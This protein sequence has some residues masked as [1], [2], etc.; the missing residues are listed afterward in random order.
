MSIVHLSNSEVYSRYRKEKLRAEMSG[1]QCETE[2]QEKIAATNVGKTSGF[3]QAD[4]TETE[5]VQ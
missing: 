3:D 2:E 4:T 1:N 5:A